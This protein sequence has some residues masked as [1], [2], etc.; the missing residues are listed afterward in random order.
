LDGLIAK[1]TRLQRFVLTSLDSL[2]QSIEFYIKG[3]GVSLAF[4]S[5][6]QAKLDINQVIVC[7]HSL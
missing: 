7:R 2:E 5:P 1:G 6:L 3:L 4:D